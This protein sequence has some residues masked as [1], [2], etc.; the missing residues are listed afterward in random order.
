MLPEDYRKLV[1]AGIVDRVEMLEGRVVMGA[2]PLIFSPAQTA[3]AR[4]LGVS[5][6]SAVDAVLQDPDAR[7]ELM[8]RLAAEKPSSR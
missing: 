7:A 6:P 1:D 4:R 8:A 3:T 5:V 2:Y